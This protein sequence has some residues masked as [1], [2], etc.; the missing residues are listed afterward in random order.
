MKIKKKISIICI[1]AF[2]F[3]LGTLC[4]W[5]IG[6][7]DYAGRGDSFFENNETTRALK[8]YKA[9]LTYKTDNY[10]LLW[11]TARCYGRLS[12]T[13]S[14]KKEIKEYALKQEEFARKAVLANP[15]GF[16]GHLYLAEALGKLLNYAPFNK[17]AKYIIEIREIAKKATELNPKEA[18]PYL[19]LGVWHRKVAQASWIKKA[20]LKTF[21]GELPH[22]SLAKSISFLEKAVLLDNTRVKYYYELAV[23]YDAVGN[24]E[25]AAQALKKAVKCKPKHQWDEKMIVSAL[26]LLNSYPQ[27]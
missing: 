25:S 22:A 18:K 12:V 7:T 23:S 21:F 16:E 27:S 2:C 15:N 9:G 20:F 13:V 6:M 11:R 19:I 17:A 10:A 24:Y 3:L 8:E 4:S 26:K 1:A 5:S 14:N